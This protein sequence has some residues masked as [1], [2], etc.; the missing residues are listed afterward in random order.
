MSLA[1]SLLATAIL[2]VAS[3]CAGAP[4]LRVCADP[5]NLPYSNKQQQGFE[6]RIASLIANDLGERVSYF[7][8]PQQEMFFQQTLDKGV[9]DIV[10]SV[11]SQFQGAD[12][13]QPYYTSSYVFL[14]RRAEHL[15]LKSFDDPRLKRLRIG[16][17]VLD[18][19]NDNLPPIFALST[20]G[21]V[22]NVISFS[23]FGDSLTQSSPASNLVRAVADKKVDVAIIW[24]PIAGYFSRNSKVPLTL[25]TIRSDPA[26]PA[27][28]FVFPI[29][30]GVR[31]GEPRL[32]QQLDAE[33]LRRHAEIARLLKAYKI[34]ELSPA[35][36]SPGSLAE[37]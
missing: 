37:N 13:T 35:A 14:S 27:L 19:G 31:K 12:T 26:H 9:C 15:D 10:M 6:N 32:K 22:R 5:A 34:P 21:I 24:G 28:Q 7:W 30:I 20:R 11:P 2:L 18:S 3:S 1:S 33:L 23:I 36:D 29:S 8:F 16:V 17:H 25:Q 4:V